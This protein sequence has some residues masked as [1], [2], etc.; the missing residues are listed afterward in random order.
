MGKNATVKR[1]EN[2]F[3]QLRPVVLE[4][5]TNTLDIEK[6]VGDLPLTP[7]YQGKLLNYAMI[8]MGVAGLGAGNGIPFEKTAAVASKIAK[9]VTLAFELTGIE[10]RT[11]R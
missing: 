11:Q 8:E 2:V 1:D 7:E 4:R 6:L 3:V 10:N 9:S 5:L